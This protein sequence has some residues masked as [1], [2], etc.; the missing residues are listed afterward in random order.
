[1]TVHRRRIET[2]HVIERDRWIDEEAEQSGAYQVPERNGEEEPNRPA[3][4]PHPRRRVLQPVRVE[5]FDPD[6][7]EGH[8]FQGAEAG[9]NRHDGGWCAREVEM[10]ERSRDARE[11]KQR[12]RADDRGPRMR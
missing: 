12:A 6:E 4:T 9:P 3:V 8:D 7:H 2:L 5:R 10:M 1:M 11:Q